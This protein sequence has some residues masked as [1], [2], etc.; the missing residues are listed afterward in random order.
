M[1]EQNLREMPRRGDVILRMAGRHFELI[2]ATSYAVLA[3]DIPSIA[4]AIEEARS[5]NASEIWQQN[6][7]VSGRPMGDPFRL[8]LPHWPKP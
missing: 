4:V 8:Q 2:D 3:C 6:L 5:R 7:D 1:S